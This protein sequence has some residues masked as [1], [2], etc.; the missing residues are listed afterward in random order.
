MWGELADICRARGMNL[1]VIIGGALGSPIGYEAQGNALYRLINRANTDGLIVTGGLGHY[2]GAA[3]LQ[4]F[5]EELRPP[6]LVSLEVRLDRF[7]SVVPNFYAG[8]ASLMRHLIFQHGYRRIAFIRG[9]ADSKTGEDRYQAYRDSLAEADLLFDPALVAPGTFFSPS[10]ADAVRLLLDERNVAFEALVAAND[11]MAVDALQALKE[12][13]IRVPGDV[14]LAGF[15]NREIAQAI[16]PPLTTVELPTDKEVRLA[17]DVIQRLLRGEDVPLRTDIETE[18]V[19]RQSC[20]CAS[21]ALQ[22]L[23]PRDHRRLAESLPPEVFPLES[24]TDPVLAW[25]SWL[26]TSRPAVLAE[27]AAMCQPLRG[28]D[29]APLEAIWDAFAEDLFSGRDARLMAALEELACEEPCRGMDPSEWQAVISAHRRHTQPLLLGTGFLQQAENLWQ[30]ARVFLGERALVLEAQRQFAADQLNATLLS[31]G[32]RLVTAFDLTV[33][34]DAVARE[35][36]RLGI[37]ACYI[38]LYGA[39]D[40]LSAD[41]RLVLAYN[42]R[43]RVSVGP[44]GCPFPTA[45]ILPEWVLPGD[46]SYAH[47]LLS[48]H[49]HDQQLG[50]VVFEPGPRNPVIYET[51]ALQLS[52][53]L[54]GA[55]LVDEMQKAR[56]AALQAQAL[57]ER[58]DQLKTRLLANVTHELRTPLN[59]ILGYSSMALLDPNPYGFELPPACAKISKTSTA[60]P[61]I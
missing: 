17:A 26:V 61:S 55:L 51:L 49:F 32:E 25:P 46:R 18:V 40:P 44:D 2:A 47:L 56:E 24:E 36:P 57:A 35:L 28:E 58:A 29:L 7:P 1:R 8:M 43:G 27:M 22:Q 23:T 37:P 41:S 16:Q 10:G 34:M 20:G 48:L 42:E 52:T 31:V 13:G 59:V 4:R 15:D 6:A 12:R 39:A 14:A 30:R 9:P 38:A 5:C 19:L 21:V 11:I 54:Q 3:G 33:L 45:S 50:Y 53:A 60:P